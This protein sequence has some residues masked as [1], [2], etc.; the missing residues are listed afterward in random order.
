MQF[1]LFWSFP[2][3]LWSDKTPA[4]MSMYK[5]SKKKYADTLCVIKF[6]DFNKYDYRKIVFCLIVQSKR[7]LK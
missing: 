1:K 4:L 7:W 6:C 2:I 5:K 3:Q